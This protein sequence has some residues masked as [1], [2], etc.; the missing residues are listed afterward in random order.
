MSTIGSAI[1]YL[2]AGLGAFLVGFRI[3]SDNV[4]KLAN[5]KLK[6]LFNKITKNKLVGVGIGTAVTMIIQSSSVTTVM[7]V[8]FVNAGVM[9]LFQATTIIMGANIGTTITAQLVAL[10]AFNIT[11][12]AMLLTAIGIFGEMFAKRDKVKSIFYALA[13]LGLVFV[14]LTVMSDAMKI[15]RTSTVITDAL[16]SI[17]NPF[18][19][20]AIGIIITGIIQSSSAVTTILISMVAAGLV[21]GSGG[22][23]VLY[24]VLGTNI[25]TCVTA[26]LSSVGASANGKRAALIHLMFNVFGTIIVFPFLFLWP[27]FMAST[28]ARWFPLPGTQIAMFHTFFNVFCT[29][30]FLPFTAVF[31]KVSQAIIPEKKVKKVATFFDERLLKT[32]GIAIGQLTKEA[33]RLGDLAMDSLDNAIKAFI[34][35]D[36]ILMD[37]TKQKNIEIEQLNHDITE[38]LIRVSTNDLSL[39]DETMISRLHHTLGDFM[40]IA[41][42]S[43]NVL[44]Y[45]KTS[46][47]RHLEFSAPVKVDLRDMF[48][49]LKSEFKLTSQIFIGKELSLLPEVEKLE[50]QI[51]L[52]RNQ[53]IDDHIKRLNQGTCSPNNS[54]VYINFVS[55]LERVGD[56]INYVAHSY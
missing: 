9:N 7:V 36:D 25:G 51:D 42:I 18:L 54:A 45:T 55:N 39:D 4:E 52:K 1:V 33:V 47:E 38:Y 35:Q 5:R 23:A 43:D 8:G 24:V 17:N 44:K 28:L 26:L 12:Y 50:D 19:L 22:N 21:I 48:D 13:G 3:L 32:P 14:G 2:L 41:E 20:L 15:F 29:L 11:A 37:K 56:H 30:I 10:Q 46:M 53:M 16:T 27:Q 34:A 49:L 6:Q 40:R 31:V